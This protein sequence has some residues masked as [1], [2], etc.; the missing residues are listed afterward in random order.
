MQLETAQQPSFVDLCAGHLA[1]SVRPF[2]KNRLELATLLQQLEGAIPVRRRELG[3]RISHG[4]LQ[5]SITAAGKLLHE[6][7]DRRI[8]QGRQDREQVGHARLIDL[9]EDDL[10]S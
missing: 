5:I 3:H 4:I 7:V 8:G 1:G 10:A 2:G 6:Y 9:I